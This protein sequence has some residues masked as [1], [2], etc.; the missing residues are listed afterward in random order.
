[1]H[2]FY[3][4]SEYRES[5]TT[6]KPAPFHLFHVPHIILL[7]Q[8]HRTSTLIRVLIFLRRQHLHPPPLVLVRRLNRDAQILRRCHHEMRVTN[9]STSEEDDVR[10]ASSKDAVRLTGCLDKADGSD[11]ERRV[12]FLQRGCE[13]D[14]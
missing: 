9:H 6:Y 3:T 2:S 5:S 7:I 1:M 13:G 12:S 8:S 14:L 11:G 4:S 10:I